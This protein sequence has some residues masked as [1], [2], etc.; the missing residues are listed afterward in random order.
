MSINKPSGK[1]IL[2]WGIFSLTT[3]IPILYYQAWIGVVIYNWLILDFTS[4]SITIPQMM[5]IQI[6]V[7]Y[8]INKFQ[9]QN[10][11]KDFN[12]IMMEITLYNITYPIFMLFLAWIVKILFV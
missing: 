8:V 2:S 1:S 6:F 4:K 5:G 3:L 9:S 12:I 7:R 11:T 10:T